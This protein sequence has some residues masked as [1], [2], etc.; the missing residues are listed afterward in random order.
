MTAR[1]SQSR[2]SSHE[3]GKAERR[4]ASRVGRGRRWRRRR[5]SEKR[6]SG[7]NGSA[8]RSPHPLD[9]P[10]R[11]PSVS[12]DHPPGRCSSLRRDVCSCGLSGL[13]TTRASKRTSPGAGDGKSDITPANASAR[14]YVFL[15][16]TGENRDL[17]QQLRRA[18]AKQPTAPRR[19]V[20]WRSREANFLLVL[21][22][23]PQNCTRK[24]VT[25]VRV[26]SLRPLRGWLLRQRERLTPASAPD[27]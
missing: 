15:T 20:R 25:R 22:V 8:R 7:E 13:F 11:L 1:G 9:L 5:E 14:R 23:C 16:C 12:S 3:G 4:A 17:S 21:P 10:R 27:D 26:A 19:R 18:T 6:E 2:S 24:R